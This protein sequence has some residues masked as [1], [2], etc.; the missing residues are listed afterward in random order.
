MSGAS[1]KSSSAS[2]ISMFR[3]SATLLPFQRTSSVS[4]ANRAPPQTSHVTQ[5]SARKSMS[6]RTEPLPS[7]ASQRPPDTLK[8]KRPAFQP[9]FLASGSIVNRLRMSSQTFT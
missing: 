3:R 8:L 4:F 1:W 2:P 7:Q 6:S 9:R 5:T